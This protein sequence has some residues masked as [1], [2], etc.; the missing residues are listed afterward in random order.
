M[1]SRDKRVAKFNRRIARQEAI[2]SKIADTKLIC[3]VMEDH[4]Y[5]WTYRD[6]KGF[7]C[8]NERIFTRKD[9]AFRKC[10]KCGHE[11]RL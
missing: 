10:N 5:I 7:L 3:S 8:R 6:Q 9:S 1:N 4:D 11:S 2:K